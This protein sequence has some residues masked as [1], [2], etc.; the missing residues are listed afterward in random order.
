MDV[1][2]DTDLRSGLSVF[3]FSAI[4]GAAFCTTL[5]RRTRVVKSAVE[6]AGSLVRDGFSVNGI[7]TGKSLVESFGESSPPRSPRQAPNSRSGTLQ[8]RD[9]TLCACLGVLHSK[10]I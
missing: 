4:R 10:A 8:Q 3:S 6:S 7:E 9:V 2:G 1:G 5:N